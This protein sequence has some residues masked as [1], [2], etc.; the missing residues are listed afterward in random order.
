MCSRLGL[1]T[2]FAICVGLPSPRRARTLSL[3]LSH[4]HTLTHKQIPRPTPSTAARKEWLFSV[5]TYTWTHNS[6][7]N[8]WA[9][10]LSADE[11]FS[12]KTEDGGR[13]ISQI[14]WLSEQKERERGAQCVCVGGG[15]GLK[16]Q[17]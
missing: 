13:I 12:K 7:L 17:Q 10:L 4:T 3:S 6:A 2:L 14:N 11:E 5:H 9:R 1:H 8:C 16:I 15:L